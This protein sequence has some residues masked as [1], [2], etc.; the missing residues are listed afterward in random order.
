MAVQQQH[1]QYT[2]FGSVAPRS[3]PREISNHIYQENEAS[4]LDK[5]SFRQQD[6][7]NNQYGYS[8][9]LSQYGN[10]PYLDSRVSLDDF[11]TSQPDF[12]TTEYEPVESH[13]NPEAP[14]FT[15]SCGSGLN[16]EATAIVPSR[17][18]REGLNPE[19]AAYL[20]AGTVWMNGWVYVPQQDF[21]EEALFFAASQLSPDE[22]AR[23]P[24]LWP[25]T[26]HHL[27]YFGQ[28][29]NGKSHTT[30]AA[31]LAIL[32]SRSKYEA[33]KYSEN[34]RISVLHARA[35][36]WLDP[37]VFV[38]NFEAIWN[39]VG[40]DLQDSTTGACYK[41]YHPSGE[42]KAD[43]WDED[44]DYPVLD[45]E[46]PD[47][48][49]AGHII[50]NGRFDESF[51]NRGDD[52][53]ELNYEHEQFKSRQW[54]KRMSRLAGRAAPKSRL[55]T[56]TTVD[57]LDQEVGCF[58]TRFD[59]LNPPLP[60]RWADLSDD[61]EDEPCKVTTDSQSLRRLPVQEEQNLSPHRGSCGSSLISQSERSLPT[62]GDDLNLTED[63]DE[64]DEADQ[65][66]PTKCLFTTKTR[67]E[68]IPEENEQQETLSGQPPNPAGT[69]FPSGPLDQAK[70]PVAGDPLPTATT[71]VNN[72]TD[73]NDIEIIGAP[74]NT[75]ITLRKKPRQ[76]KALRV[77]F[78]EIN[79]TGLPGASTA[80][81]RHKRVRFS[82]PLVTVA[83][84]PSP[85]ASP[86]FLLDSSFSITAAFTY[87]PQRSTRLINNFADSAAARDSSEH[88][89]PTPALPTFTRVRPGWS[90]R[91]SG[92]TNFGLKTLSAPIDPNLT[93]VAA[94][95]VLTVPYRRQ[96]SPSRWA[97]TGRKVWEKVKGLVVK[98]ASD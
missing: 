80:I 56:C 7:L 77:I 15:P 64:E 2:L 24:L 71:A 38:G 26:F 5:H 16:P 3:G 53:A 45:P 17:S 49:N 82:F 13:L 4:S 44:D 25:F 27:N 23:A 39:L 28:Q 72:A 76:Q 59:A 8:D 9:C 19:A 22:C 12:Q 63:E 47:K 41:F 21:D 67:L 37:L 88:L 10:N 79:T 65:G 69:L 61:E 1:A 31:T 91:H 70:A 83:Y 78:K 66:P 90:L 6:P 62:Q 36:R 86:T 29:I 74:I 30:P 11:N 35:T 95:G 52:I 46:D 92:W 73:E 96:P 58:Q 68:T 20:P 14:S 81:A 32:K 55:H 97:K 94:Q 84:H 40:T 54:E 42:W 51:F 60:S 48:Y 89:T 57:D 43:D 18:L 93:R 50:I 98:N 33:A 75:N 85:P 87:G 34:L